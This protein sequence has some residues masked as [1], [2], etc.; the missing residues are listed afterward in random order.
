MLGRP[1]KSIR[2]QISKPTRLLF[3]TVIVACLLRLLVWSYENG[4]ENI[5]YNGRGI[6]LRSTAAFSEARVL[7]K[8]TA[9]ALLLSQKRTT[10]NSERFANISST[11]DA[12]IST[13]GPSAAPSTSSTIGVP[14]QVEGLK[15]RDGFDEIEYMEI[16]AGKNAAKRKIRGQ[17]SIRNA[18]PGGIQIWTPHTRTCDGVFVSQN[19]DPNREGKPP[20]LMIREAAI[21]L[22]HNSLREAK[23]RRIQRTRKRVVLQI[24]VA[25]DGQLLGPRQPLFHNETSFEASPA[26]SFSVRNSHNRS[27]GAW[28]AEVV[29]VLGE[30][31][32]VR[33]NVRMRV[34]T[35]F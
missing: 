26:A 21:D 35:K 19:T 30:V 9:P 10:A 1:R 32:C 24:S 5:V 27:L 33:S 18:R 29:Y 4:I 7:S 14:A 8:W 25:R 31:N 34:Y 28:A 13:L 17:R 6:V 3:C 12:H 16:V 11:S 23:F 2:S 22:R 20:L 15:T